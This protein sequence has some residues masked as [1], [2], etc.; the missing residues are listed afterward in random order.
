MSESERPTSPTYEVAPLTPAMPIATLRARRKT[1]AQDENGS[2]VIPVVPPPASTTTVATIAR[3][4]ESRVRDRKPSQP[5]EKI[6]ILFPTDSRL[7]LPVLTTAHAG[8]V[9]I[10]NRLPLNAPKTP[11]KT[12]STREFGKRPPRPGATRSKAKVQQKRPTVP[13]SPPL[14]RTLEAKGKVGIAETLDYELLGTLPYGA[15][16]VTPG[17]LREGLLTPDTAYHAWVGAK[18]A[19]EERCVPPPGE[20]DLARVL[21]DAMRF[22]LVELGVAILEQVEGPHYTFIDPR[23]HDNTGAMIKQALRLVRLFTKKGHRRERIIVTIPATEAGVQA[24]KTLEG[25]HRVQTNLTLVSGLEHAAV[26]AEAAAT[27][28]TLCHKEVSEACGRRTGSNNPFI[29]AWEA[30]NSP[31]RRLAEEAIQSAA[32]Y[33]NMH[34]LGTSIV[35]ANL[36][37]PCVAENLGEFDGIAL[38]TDQSLRAR[39]PTH[40]VPPAAAS[41]AV[42]LAKKHASAAQY[43]TSYLA[44]K[45]GAFLSAMPVDARAVAKLTLSTGLKGMMEQMH[46]TSMHLL[47]FIQGEAQLEQLDDVGLQECYR[48]DDLEATR[49]E[50]MKAAGRDV[51]EDFPIRWWDVG[52][53]MRF[54][55]W[56]QP[57]AYRDH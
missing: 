5:A 26:C 12:D 2:F 27:C 54:S 15:S 28:V 1:N 42:M 52:F 50:K 4:E 57:E 33:F 14:W 17:M 49:V 8:F 45:D 34:E 36:Q 11:E 51:E 31:P 7:A 46:Q 9:D 43:P 40:G 6:S 21:A 37:G 32:A 44:A 41:A 25:E 47:E 23:L 10:T 18:R 29:R 22:Y 24:A 16:M 55:T 13:K 38:T 35:V 56:D 48:A 20:W 19:I 3:D 53:R 30:I 39:V